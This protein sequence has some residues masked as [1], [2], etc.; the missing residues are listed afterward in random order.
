MSSILK[1]VYFIFA[2]ISG[3]RTVQ[4]HYNRCCHAHCEQV[5]LTF[6]SFDRSTTLFSTR[7]SSF[8]WFWEHIFAQCCHGKF[9][10]LS[11]KICQ[12]YS[13]FVGFGFIPFWIFFCPSNKCRYCCAVKDT[14][15]NRHWPAKVD[16]MGSVPWSDNMTFQETEHIHTYFN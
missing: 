10:K 3:K 16:V 2:S 11:T 12:E 15:E 13:T 7:F 4:V 9:Y 5:C 6:L 1:T 8:C 14:K